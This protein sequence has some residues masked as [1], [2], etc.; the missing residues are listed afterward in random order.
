MS[1]KQAQ[2][3]LPL[4][5]TGAS[6][7]WDEGVVGLILTQ[8]YFEQLAPSTGRLKYWNGSSWITKVLKYWNGS[9]WQEKPLKYW[10]GISWVT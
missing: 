8:E 6:D 2:F 3:D 10:N 1:I 4:G 9:I 5:I 7:I